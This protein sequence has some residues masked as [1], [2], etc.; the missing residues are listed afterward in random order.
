MKNR[1]LSTQYFGCGAEGAALCSLRLYGECDLVE[2]EFAS[3]QEEIRR[4]RQSRS[5]KS[6]K[7][8]AP[9]VR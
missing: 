9:A 3:V 2:I 5:A 8:V 7:I 6:R 4:K 1:K